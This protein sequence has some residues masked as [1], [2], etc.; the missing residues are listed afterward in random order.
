MEVDK[1]G[2]SARREPSFALELAALSETRLGD[3]RPLSLDLS[4][5]LELPALRPSLWLLEASVRA[6]GADDLLLDAPLLLLE[7]DWRSRVVDVFVVFILLPLL[8]K[9]EGRRSSRERSR[10]SSDDARDCDDRGSGHGGAKMVGTAV[11]TK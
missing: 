5:L 9:V 10:E 7:V 3:E 2:A 4:L 8:D 11:G 6:E 1:L